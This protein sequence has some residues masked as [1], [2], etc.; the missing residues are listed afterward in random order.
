MSTVIRH[1]DLNKIDFVTYKVIVSIFKEF[2]PNYGLRE[3]QKVRNG[4]QGLNHL[5]RLP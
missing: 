2:R 5:V 4:R 1:I 3:T